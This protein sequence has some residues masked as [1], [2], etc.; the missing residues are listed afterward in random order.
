MMANEWG[1]EYSQYKLS[2]NVIKNN[3]V[4]SARIALFLWPDGNGGG[5]MKNTDIYGNTFEKA[6]EAVVDI[7]S[8]DHSGSKLHDNTFGRQWNPSVKINSSTL[9]TYNNTD[10]Y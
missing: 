2:G 7:G 9:S 10:Q 5:P 8:G 1:P 3:K 4:S 6:T